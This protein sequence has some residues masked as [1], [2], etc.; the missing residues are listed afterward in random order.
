MSRI[1]T[2]LLLAQILA[3]IVA[4]YHF[5]NY[6]HS[7]NYLRS[8]VGGGESIQ[9][10]EN[11]D[12]WDG[13]AGTD[14][15]KLH[16][17]CQRTR[18]EQQSWTN[19]TDIQRVFDETT[20]LNNNSTNYDV[21]MVVSWCDEDVQR[22]Q[23]FAID[24]KVNRLYIYSKCQQ[25]ITLEDNFVAQFRHVEVTELPNVGREGHSFLTHMLR[26]DVVTNNPNGW[27][28][29]F[30]GKIEKMLPQAMLSLVA[31]HEHDAANDGTTIINM[32]R[33]RP[34]IRRRYMDIFYRPEDTEKAG[35]CT[36]IHLPSLVLGIPQKYPRY[37]H[38]H[39][40]RKYL[41]AMVNQIMYRGEFV[42]KNS[43][44][45]SNNLD[46]DKVLDIQSRLEVENA[47]REGYFLEP[48]WT[49]VLGGA[50][51]CRCDGMPVNKLP[52]LVP[53]M[54]LQKPALQSRTVDGDWYYPENAND[55]E[56]LQTY[57]STQP[58][59]G[60]DRS[61]WEVD[62]ESTSIIRRVTLYRPL[63]DRQTPLR[64]ATMEI[65]DVDFQVVASQVIEPT[66]DLVVSRE[67]DYIEGRL[68]RI[69]KKAGILNLA[70]VEVAGYPIVLTPLSQVHRAYT[71]KPGVEALDVV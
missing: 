58:I 59:Q 14:A 19:D 9:K 60:E 23:S 2:V 42:A 33:V 25:N 62:L 40:S 69:A 38:P 11:N 56:T 32:F 48:L 30:Q 36:P 34:N 64:N 4:F 20:A 24:L 43:L 47:P 51:N 28:I 7:S 57:A 12:E 66:E 8:L 15:R 45:G 29:F 37:Q 6:S 71:P 63:V 41:D 17:P 44:F 21:D 5:S 50:D 35:F 39:S 55:G 54:A 13:I 26:E 70:Q 52:P 53:N 22:F 1:S 46:F 68:V 18:V 10:E 16:P 49:S 31:A 67:F 27:T 65:L 61:W 3:V